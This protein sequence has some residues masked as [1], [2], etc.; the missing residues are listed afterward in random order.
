MQFSV[1]CTLFYWVHKTTRETQNIHPKF[2]RLDSCSLDE[3]DIP[4]SGVSELN[5]G[6]FSL[7]I[8]L[9]D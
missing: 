8:I 4:E 9:K 6:F 2:P 5:S 7:F 3:R 1:W